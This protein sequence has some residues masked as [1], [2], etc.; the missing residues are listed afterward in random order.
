MFSNK[1]VWKLITYASRW[2]SSIL[3][4]LGETIAHFGHK[5]HYS[6]QFMCREFVFIFFS[7]LLF[8]EKS[9]KIIYL[10]TN[11]IFIFNDGKTSLNK[12]HKKLS[13]ISLQIHPVKLKASANLCPKLFSC[14]E[15]TKLSKNEKKKI[16][17]LQIHPDWFSLHILKWRIVIVQTIDLFMN[18]S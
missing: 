15:L 1:F 16:Q 11:S 12:T 14:H 9:N 7:I 8:I 2:I 18:L 4:I 5:R 6:I 17:I 13:F 10:I 3:S